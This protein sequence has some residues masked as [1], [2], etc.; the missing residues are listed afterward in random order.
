MVEG[1]RKLVCI[2]VLCVVLDVRIPL[3][4]LPLL[5]GAEIETTAIILNGLKRC[6]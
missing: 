1:A 4:C 3:D 6:P 5:R 2:E